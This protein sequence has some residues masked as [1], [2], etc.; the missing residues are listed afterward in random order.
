M[1]ELSNDI[2]KYRKGELNPEEM[3]KLEKRALS[4][5]FLA[6]ALDG[7]ETISSQDLSND[8]K[9]LNGRIRKEKNIIFTPLRIAAGLFVVLGASFLFYLVSNQADEEKNL[10]AKTKNKSDSSAGPT[11]KTD[12]AKTE[13][14]ITL[15][16]PEKIKQDKTAQPPKQDSSTKPIS[17]GETV[18]AISAEE[19]TSDSEDKKAEEI[20]E[21]E[22]I[23][24]QAPAT[25]PILDLKEKQDQ[26]KIAATES[27]SQL[28]SE[29]LNRKEST[30]AKKS[31]SPAAKSEASGSSSYQ[32]NNNIRGQVTSAS[33]GSPMPGVNVVLRGTVTGTITDDQGNYVI[34]LPE[35]KAP[36]LV[37][38]FIGAQT[39]EV[40]VNDQSV[41]NVQMKE[42]VSQLSEVVVVGYGVADS[43][44][45]PVI[46][47]LLLAEPTGGK[48]SFKKYMETNLQYPQQALENKIEGRVTIQF[49]VRS[50]GGL[51][52]FKVIK[53][54]GYGCENEV[55]RLI[56][57]G[58]KW[59]PARKAETPIASRFR[60][61]MR[62]KLPD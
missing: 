50:D 11:A 21:K 40:S 23:T 25:Q 48:R 17:S 62:F 16:E 5:P 59:S 9:D 14:L 2:K 26:Q 57:S 46:P 53:G 24:E 27:E 10:T 19:Q 43:T 51:E 54:L 45:E 6:D 39:D 58:P 44:P 20:T 60:L 37:F 56:K 36:A 47:T 13:N 49:T 4:D 15:K 8:L 3:H 29:S 28:R 31:I 38:S 35:V 33:D 34:E 18:T 1:G 52:D 61:R 41:L 22:E 7:L 12:S 32:I 30:R 42:D 55:I